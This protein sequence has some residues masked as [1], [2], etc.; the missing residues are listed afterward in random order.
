M[1]KNKNKSSGR[2]PFLRYSNGKAFVQKRK[3][4]GKKGNVALIRGIFFLAACL[5]TTTAVAERLKTYQINLPNQSVAESLAS[6]SEQIDVLLLFPYEIAKELKANSVRGE[7]TLP[8]ALEIM[9]EGTGF[10]GRLSEKGVLMISLMK[11]EDIQENFK[12]TES[13]EKMNTN[14][15]LLVA[16]MGVFSGASGVQDAIAQDEGRYGIE[17]IVVTAQKRAE[18]LQDVPITISAFTGSM[19]Q[20]SGVQ[21]TDDLSV[22]VP[23]LQMGRDTGPGVTFLRGVGTKNSSAGEES[24]VPTY[25]DGVLVANMISSILSFNNIERIE[26]LKGPQG[27]LFGR[28]ATGGLIHILTKDPQQDFSSNLKASYGTYGTVET[29]LYATGGLVD[30]IAA[31]IA[32][33]YAN[34]DKGYGDNQVTGNDT[35]RAYIHSRAVRSNFL[36]DFS[37]KTAGRLTFDYREHKDNLAIARQP[38][39]GAVGLDGATTYSGDFY[40]IQADADSF[41]FSRSWG[42]SFKLSHQFDQMDFVSISAYREGHSLQILD[43]DATPTNFVTAS[44][45]ID[46]EFFSQEF[47]LLSSN[48]S[49]LQWMLGL[50]YMNDTSGYRPF[51]LEGSSIPGPVGTRF[52]GDSVQDTESYAAFGQVTYDIV[53]STSITVGFR[54]TRD[55]REL[56]VDRFLDF[57]ETQSLLPRIDKDKSWTEPTWRVSVDHRVSNDVMIFGSYSRGFKSGIFNTTGIMSVPDTTGPVNPEIL[58]AYEIGVK[59][60]LLDNRVRLNTGVFYY[61]YSDMQLSR[62][63]EGTTQLLNAAEAEILGAELDITAMVSDNLE[64]Y[65]GLSLLDT[66]YKKFP[67]APISIQNPAGGNTMDAG[68]ASGKKLIRTPDYTLNIGGKYAIPSSVGEFGLSLNYYYN[69]GFFW[70]PENRLKQDAYHVLNADLSWS[71]I[72]GKSKISIFGKNLT[73]DK[74]SYHAISGALGDLISGGAPR[75]SGIAVE[76]NF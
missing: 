17:E 30:S 73:N 38:A 31:D 65:F 72:N 26:V 67:G 58:D 23:G 14:K 9:L 50:Y 28:N 51:E 2:R 66:E 29:S 27:T 16:L 64:L 24:S 6:L 43:Q 45:V 69:D 11:S 60:F 20:N 49:R 61:E 13:G 56:S 36:V 48:D 5:L 21:K 4:E 63:S 68:D 47:Q 40:D 62:T 70:E 32:V 15:N 8:E 54:V 12:S 37:E 33:S 7:Y 74:Y 42:A 57:G 41:T 46:S 76:Y 53:D 25:V 1:K 59:S 19:L 3:L 35:N 39:P 75:T 55:E 34:Q 71:S 52:L 44:L 18:N 22:I 10:S